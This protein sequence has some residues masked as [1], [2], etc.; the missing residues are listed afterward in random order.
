MTGLV[1]GMGIIETDVVPIAG[2]RNYHKEIA[3]H[4]GNEHNSGMDD[5]VV[6]DI[7]K[8]G[9]PAGLVR[10]DCDSDDGTKYTSRA[11]SR[12]STI[13]TDISNGN[14]NNDN[15][16]I[17]DAEECPVETIKPSEHPPGK[18]P[19]LR[20]STLT[21][22]EYPRVLG[23][24]VTVM[25]PPISIS[26]THQEETIYD[27]EDYEEACRYTRR[28][29]SE[30][31]MPSK[32]R[33]KILKENGF[34]K[35]EIQNAVKQS[36]IAR[37]QRKRTVEMLKMQPLHETFEKVVRVGKKNPF[38]RKSSKKDLCEK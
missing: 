9:W 37:N 21:I 7:S 4:N 1:I 11:S 24:N 28:T 23:D 36:N 31:K 12:S 34:S 26:W 5:T 22:R 27:L 15:N 6:K 8:D 20:F 10:S 29:Q 32:H 16:E 38:R 33:D 35:Q 2:D 3:I 25:G 30:L 13:E 17:D 19:R 18:R 14:C